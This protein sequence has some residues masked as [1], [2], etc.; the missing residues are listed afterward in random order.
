MINRYF[1]IF[2]VAIISLSII[3][4]SD[5][6]ITG[7][8]LVT[9][10]NVSINEFDD[11]RIVYF[12]YPE[13][14]IQYSK[15]YFDLEFINIGNTDFTKSSALYIGTYDSNMT[16][17]KNSNGITTFLKQG[18]RNTERFGFLAMDTGFYWIHLIVSYADKDIDVWG[19]FYVDPYY[20]VILP[21]PSPPPV[22]DISSGVSG[23]PKPKYIPS[24]PIPIDTGDILVTVS[25]P[26]T[27]KIPSGESSVV[28]V[29][30]NN[31]GTMTLRNLMLLPRIVGNISLDAQPMNVQT[32]L[33]N[34]SALFMI[35][36]DVPRGTAAGVY[37]LDFKV[38][39]NKI[40]RTGHIDVIV[41]SISLDKSIMDTILNYQYILTKLRDDS[42]TL[43]LD[44]KNVS[45]VEQYLDDAE[46]MLSLAKEVYALGDPN[47][48][49]D[50]VLI[51]EHLKNAIGSLIKAV[52][53]IA[54]LRNEGTLVV[55]APTLWLL[56]ILIL[57][58]IITTTMVY[59]HKH[60]LKTRKFEFTEG[61]ELL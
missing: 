61:Q 28:Y 4:Q 7:N 41:G 27:I 23:T 52:K 9:D 56:F 34:Q 5:P 46:F 17:V 36:L 21:R 53:E 39:S 15:M 24:P 35:V 42:D 11:G 45:V 32:L 16:V 14:I 47:S 43:V 33:G 49:K 51:R 60:N 29:I 12:T 59:I 10:I 54:N 3:S 50:Y 1:V 20:P 48:P 44:G 37:P 58:I 19:Y 31:T 22:S 57:L 38:F 2:I 25:N 8:V 40:N 13:K 26:D 6:S 18:E 55:R 30:V